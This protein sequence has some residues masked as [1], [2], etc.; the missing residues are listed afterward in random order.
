MTSA[1][2]ASIIEGHE[3]FAAAW[4]KGDVDAV[5]QLFADDAVRVGVAG[6]VQRGRAEI[7]GAMEH[8]LTRVFPG[9]TVTIARGEVR[10]LAADVALWRGSISIQPAGAPTPLHGHAIDVLKKS[11]RGWLIVETHP[12]LFPPAR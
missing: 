9:A 4:S 3:R 10:F 1:D 6:D 12:K 11:A 2:E 8:V 7:R 5:M